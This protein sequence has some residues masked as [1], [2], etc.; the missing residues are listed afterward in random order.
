MDRAETCTAM[1]IQIIIRWSR[2]PSPRRIFTVRN[3]F[4]HLKCLAI[5]H[6]EEVVIGDRA[7]GLRCR[8][9]GWHSPGW[10]LD[11]PAHRIVRKAID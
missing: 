8:Y 11:G 1:Q 5:G 6:D 2:G 4:R 9:C 10:S 7:L 3:A